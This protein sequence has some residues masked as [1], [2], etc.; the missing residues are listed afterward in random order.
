VQLADCAAFA[1]LKREVPPTPH[2]KKYRIH[3]LFDRSL[4]PICFRKASYS[5]PLGVVRK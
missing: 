1:L 5:D 2:V 3:K 4:S